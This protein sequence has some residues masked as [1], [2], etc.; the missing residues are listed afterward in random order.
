[1]SL[2]GCMRLRLTRLRPQGIQCGNGSSDENA[3]QQHHMI[4]DTVVSVTSLGTRPKLMGSN[5]T[6]GRERKDWGSF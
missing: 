2:V 6:F 1:M 5:A 4:C 3:V